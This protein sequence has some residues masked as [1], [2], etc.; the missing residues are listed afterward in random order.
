MSSVTYLGAQLYRLLAERADAIAKATG[1]VQRRR[2]FSGASLLQTLV[3]GWQQHPDA[4]LEQLAST[5]ATADVLVTDTAVDKRFTPQAA[6]FLH[7]MLEEACSIVVQAAHDVPLPLLRRFSAVLLEDS[8]S[9]SLP[10]ELAQIWRGCGGNQD[11]TAAAVK[12]H[13]RWELKRGQLWGP[14]LTD[15]R[16]SDRRSPLTEE[17]IAPGS[18]SVKDLG[19]FNLEHIAARRAAGAYTL[20]R[21][22][23][24]TALLTPEGKRLLL[25]K[26][27]PQ[28]VGQMKE[29]PVLVG[30]TR[31][32]PMR[33]LLLKVPKEVGDQRRKDLLADA[34]RRGQTISEETL[35][36]ADW[37][38]LLTDVPAK[39]LRFEEALVLLRERWQMELLYKLWK[40]EGVIDEWR[41]QNPWRVL[42]EL[43]A[44]LL[45]QLLQH[46]LIVV[47]A[48]QD[49]QR[50]LVKLAQQVRDTSWLLM[51]ALAGHRSVRSAL[52]VIGRRMRAGCQMNKR[53]TRPN[54][55]Q[56]LER[57]AVEWALSW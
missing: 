1:C 43:Y 32:H 49:P 36:L 35:R 39:R 40:S 22:Q 4:S 17:P 33:L 52:Q 7:A 42:C 3:F 11:H 30:A 28:R 24:G 5:A 25:H 47:F 15:G 53:K 37:T 27:V 51:D 50:S 14:K 6:R 45:G 16:A 31:R 48:W 12:L 26:V 29:L 10:N 20:T 19:Y 55:A 18:L 23:A 57:Q 56:L 2:K 13:V 44:K 9:I 54:S 8:S 34:Q 41:T 38:I 46:W 21:W